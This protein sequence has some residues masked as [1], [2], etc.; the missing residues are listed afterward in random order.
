LKNTPLPRSKKRTIAGEWKESSQEEVSLHIPVSNQP[1]NHPKV[2]LTTKMN[3][4]SDITT[5]YNTHWQCYKSTVTKIQRPEPSGYTDIRYYD[6]FKVTVHNDL[7][8]PASIPFMID[9]YSPANITGVA[10]IL[11]DALGNPLGYPLQISKNW[12]L[13]KDPNYV[14]I[15]T[16]LPCLPGKNEFTIR[17]AY[18]FY[19][20]LPSASHAQLSLVDY[21]GNARWDQLAIGC[22]GETICFDMDQSCVDNIITDVR[23]LTTRNGKLGKKWSWTDAGWGGDWL[24]AYNQQGGKLYLNG[25]KTAY[26]THGPCLTDVHSQGFFGENKEVTFKS[27]IQTTRTDDH[28]RTFIKLKYTIN[29]KLSTDKLCFLKMGSKQSASNRAICYGN[30]EGLLKEI[31]LDHK[32]Q[33]YELPSLETISGPP[34]WWIG[35]LG[36]RV[37][38]NSPHSQQKGG[39]NRA[40]VITKYRANINGKEYHNPSFSVLNTG[41]I[42][43]LPTSEV[44]LIY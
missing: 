38:S 2:T 6:D 5:D 29:Q 24:Q 41:S 19:G 22:W 20:T 42:S 25:T 16:K 14:K 12:H 37:T 13:G 26:N 9:H 39:G 4:K 15:F 34:P 33:P 32:N 11:C 28:A 31:T 7:E 17:L 18:G 3:Y 36:N 40:F 10:P 8:K 27:K 23:T 1:R 44:L 35:K 30:Q 21:R 43:G